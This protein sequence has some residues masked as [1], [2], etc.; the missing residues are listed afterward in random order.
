MIDKDIV[1]LCCV[2][3][4]IVGDCVVMMFVLMMM[5]FLESKFIGVSVDFYEKCVDWLDC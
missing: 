4:N 3:I 2:F 5:E 1:V